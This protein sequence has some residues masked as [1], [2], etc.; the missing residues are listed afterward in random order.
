MTRFEEIGVEIQ[1]GATS[2][3]KENRNAEGLRLAPISF[4]GL[5]SF[6]G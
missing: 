1:Y 5:R 4:L 2:K 6:N 3:R